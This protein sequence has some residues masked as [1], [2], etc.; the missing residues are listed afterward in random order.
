MGQTHLEK[1]VADVFPV[2]INQLNAQIVQ[3]VAREKKNPYLVAAQNTISSY[4]A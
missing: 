3:I 2:V 4:E 1:C